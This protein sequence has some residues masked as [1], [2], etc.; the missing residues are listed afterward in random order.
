M[1]AKKSLSSDS[2]EEFKG[3]DNGREDDEDAGQVNVDEY[4]EI[5]GSL[6]Y[7]DASG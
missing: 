7:E 1:L 5:R 6:V 2:D 4:R 3:G